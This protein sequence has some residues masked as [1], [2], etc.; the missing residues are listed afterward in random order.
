[1]NKKKKTHKRT[2][3]VKVRLFKLDSQSL[4]KLSHILQMGKDGR[5]EVVMVL[6][7]KKK[8]QDEKKMI[9]RK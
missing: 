4:Q 8:Q 1:M 3:R 9:K 2:S 6:T 7:M 5:L